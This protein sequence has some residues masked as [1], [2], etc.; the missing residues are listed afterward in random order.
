MATFYG[1]HV[2]T[3]DSKRRLPVTAAFRELIDTESEGENFVLILWGDGRLRLY[4]NRYYGDLI[5]ALKRR[6]PSAAAFRET[7][8]F[9]SD[10]RTVKPDAQGR[11]VLPADVIAQANLPDEVVLRGIDDHIELWRPE[12]YQAARAAATAPD[13]DQM[14][15]E[16]AQLLADDSSGPV[17]II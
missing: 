6:T 8:E 17:R 15:H 14:I 12:E 3:I 11:V 7:V 1:N 4:P 2:Q 5:A 9:L 10:G 16:A 13:I